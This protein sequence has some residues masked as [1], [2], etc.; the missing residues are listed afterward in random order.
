MPTSRPSGS[1]SL[2]SE[3]VKA[4][5]T[6]LAILQH[7]TICWRAHQ[8]A[9]GAYGPGQ[10]GRWFFVADRSAAFN[11]LPSLTFDA[12]IVPDGNVDHPAEKRG[13]TLL[14]AGGL[15]TFEVIGLVVKH[16][17]SSAV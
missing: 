4:E 6:V 14:P 12:V 3:G 7:L 15:Q 17:V 13:C 16:A 5:A 10:R 8:T 1:R 9:G 11:G 2:L